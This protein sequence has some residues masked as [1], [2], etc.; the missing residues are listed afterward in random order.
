MPEGQ[1]N[2]FVLTSQMQ[3]PGH[4]TVRGHRPGCQ[5]VIIA[6]PIV[7]V[8][9]HFT[10]ARLRFVKWKFAVHDIPFSAETR[11]RRATAFVS[12]DFPADCRMN[13]QVKVQSVICLLYTS[14]SPRD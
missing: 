4:P 6:A 13:R 5:R 9:H 3:L 8:F 11:L 2:A 12:A 7:P 14:P 10:D 1:D